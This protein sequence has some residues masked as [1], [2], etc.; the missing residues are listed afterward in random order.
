MNRDEIIRMA[1][2]AG[3]ALCSDPMDEG[4]KLRLQRFAALVAAAEREECAKVADDQAQDEPYG[5][6][7]FRCTSIAT[8]IRARGEK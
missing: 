3:F 6:A 1:R 7:K 4:E 8:A 2:K 5:H